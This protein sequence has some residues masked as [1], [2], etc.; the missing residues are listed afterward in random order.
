MTKHA[1]T[2]RSTRP[3]SSRSVWIVAAVVG[4][5]LVAGVVLLWSERGEEDPEGGAESEQPETTESGSPGPDTAP[6]GG[7]VWSGDFGAAGWQ[8][9]FGVVVESRT[10]TEV[11]AEGPD[12]RDDVLRIEFG[13]DD[14][15]WGMDY[16]HAF[17]ELGLPE[18]DAVN[19][20]YDVYFSPDFE[21]IGDGKIGGISGIED[22]VDPLETASGGNYDERSFS[23][24]AMW[25]EDRGVVMYLYARGASGRDFRDPEH[26]GFGIAEPFVGPGGRTS[27][28]FTPGTWHRIEHRIVL[29]TPGETDGVYQLYV[30]GHRGV[31]LDDVEY[32]TEDHPDLRINQ[33]MSTWFFGGGSDEFPTR[34]NTAF[35][36]DWV[37]SVP[38]D[39]GT[40]SRAS[41][42]TEENR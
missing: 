3:S 34:R 33:L 42:S 14:E 24:R 12:G 9:R 28:I 41:T 32:R 29:N 13:E 35:T 4:L 19:F 30:D 36:D 11:V 23:A 5:L 26:F 37:L 25:K 1:G 6:Q 27:E 20:A 21:F 8:D 31:D 15:R 17:D 16:R 39:R 10:N 7:V 22:D 40:A 38:E 2:E 18:L